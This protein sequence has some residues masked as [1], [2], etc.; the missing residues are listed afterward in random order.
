MAPRLTP[1]GWGAARRRQPWRG[2]RDLVRR[3]SMLAPSS[4]NVHYVIYAFNDINDL[5]YSA[6]KWCMHSPPSSNSGIPA[7]HRSASIF[8]QM[9][10]I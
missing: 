1:P 7:P 5:A 10:N 4:D 2:L 3:R 8:D 6:L 9:V